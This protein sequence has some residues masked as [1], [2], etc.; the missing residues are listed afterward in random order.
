MH[1]FLLLC[2]VL[3]PCINSIVVVLRTTVP[4][5][6]IPGGLADMQPMVGGDSCTFCKSYRGFCMK[7]GGK[8][9]GQALPSFMKL[10]PGRKESK[11]WYCTGRCIRDHWPLSVTIMR[12]QFFA[13]RFPFQ[14]GQA[15]C[16]FIASHQSFHWM[17]PLQSCRTSPSFVV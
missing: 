14:K 6:P 5:V 3:L 7:G 2:I 8:D 10:S 12:T 9:I 11:Y 16:V 15:Q 17:S 13:R 1:L 4:F